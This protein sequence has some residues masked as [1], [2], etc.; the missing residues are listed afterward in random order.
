VFFCS[1]T[2][3]PSFVVVIMA[4]INHRMVMRQVQNL[5][6][7]VKALKILKISRD[8]N[9]LPSTSIVILLP[10]YCRSHLECFIHVVDQ[11]IKIKRYSIEMHNKEQQSAIFEAQLLL[12]ANTV[13]AEVRA[14]LWKAKREN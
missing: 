3:D 14:L 13:D 7:S 9:K 12:L 2:R 11:I 8:Q 6:L 5:K 1:T 10:Y 4:P